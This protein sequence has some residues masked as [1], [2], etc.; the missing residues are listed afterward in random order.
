M[1][2]AGL[3]A[4]ITVVV[5]A[6]LISMA[7]LF[8]CYLK[9]KRNRAK[10]ENF[11]E[12]ERPARSSYGRIFKDPEE[13]NPEYLNFAAMEYPEYPLMAPKS[14]NVAQVVTGYDESDSSKR[15]K[16][17]TV[18]GAMDTSKSASVAR[19]PLSGEEESSQSRERGSSKKSIKKHRKKSSKKLDRDNS[20]WTV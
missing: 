15:S 3:I 18:P 7:V 1:A 10:A 14:V 19:S 16:T 4:G 2:S 11:S 6:I 9:R 5:V 12:K 13:N 17:G 8:L 20:P